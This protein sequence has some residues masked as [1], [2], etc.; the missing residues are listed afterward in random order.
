MPP[1]TP[2]F[3]AWHT[4]AKRRPWGVK[5]LTPLPAICEL[6]PDLAGAKWR[7]KEIQTDGKA[8]WE[9]G[10]CRN[11]RADARPTLGCVLLSQL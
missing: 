10:L 5:S 8:L 3:P 7:I 4:S 9:G 1:K 6:P 11:A 2:Q